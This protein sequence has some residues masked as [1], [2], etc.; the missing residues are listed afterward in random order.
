MPLQRAM[1]DFG[2]ERSFAKAT[3]GLKEHY[4][5]ELSATA[6]RSIT[7]K[8]AHKVPE[9]AA[10][11][12]LPS[13]GPSWVVAQTDGSFVPIVEFKEGK[14]DKRTRRKKEYKEVRL[15]VAYAHKSASA[16][17]ASGGFCNVEKTGKALARAALKAGW[18]AQGS[19]HCMGDGAA[20]IA[21]QAQLQFGSECF[22]LDFFH[23]CEYLHPAAQACNPQHPEEWIQQQA[24][25]LKKSESSKVIEAMEPYIEKENIADNNAPV[26]CAH[27]YLSNRLEQLDYKSALEKELPIGSGKIESAHG[28]IIQDRMKKSGA[29]WDIKNADAM[30]NIRVARANLEWEACWN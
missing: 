15:C 12:T 24:Q 29:A 22:L 11:R 25:W 8:H 23:V 2:C 5:I 17:Y 28:H 7:L 27:R 4:G 1:T 21:K 3:L 13:R 14:G 10:V 6:E 30:I 19:V 20:W 16:H 18:N 9:A 26:R